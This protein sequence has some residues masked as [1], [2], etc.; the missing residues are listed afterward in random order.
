MILVL[1]PNAFREGRSGLDFI[2]T[3]NNDI[4]LAGA[5]DQDFIP[6][7]GLICDVLPAV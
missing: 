4:D 6:S 3:G 7:R 5:A 1:S 2:M